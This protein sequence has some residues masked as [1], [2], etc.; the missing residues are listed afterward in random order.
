MG[1]SP[2]PAAMITQI[3]PLPPRGGE[4]RNRSTRGSLAFG[5]ARSLHTG[6]PR[7]NA[8]VGLN[9]HRIR[10]GL[11]RSMHHL[12]GAPRTS[13]G[14]PRAS[15]TCAGGSARRATSPRCL[16]GASH[17]RGGRDT[18]PAWCTQRFPRKFPLFAQVYVGRSCG[19]I[20]PYSLAPRPPIAPPGRSVGRRWCCACGSAALPRR[21]FAVFMVGIRPRVTD[22]LMQ[23]SM[24]I[25]SCLLREFPDVGVE[26]RSRDSHEVADTFGC[27]SYTDT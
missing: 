10:A 4:L 27:N 17:L 20:P 18:A 9:W 16:Q 12:L 13:R 15:A 21:A 2:Y 8:A 19:R 1:L 25:A 3:R 5:P 24:S 14:R 11:G 7:G 6:S 23:S 26:R 22:S